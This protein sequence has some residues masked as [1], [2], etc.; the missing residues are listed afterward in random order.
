MK[1]D[2]RI[3]GGGATALRCARGAEAQVTLDGS[4]GLAGGGKGGYN[5]LIGVDVGLRG[6]KAAW[7]GES[8]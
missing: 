3:I 2:V 7:R 4:D 6:G 5:F 1:K 8:V